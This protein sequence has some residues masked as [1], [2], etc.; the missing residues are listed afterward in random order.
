MKKILY[1][2]VLCFFQ[3]LSAQRSGSVSLQWSEKPYKLNDRFQFT[4]PNFQ[5]ENFSY[6]ETRKV[7]VFTKI[8]KISDGYSGNTIQV[9]NVVYETISAEKL[10]ELD[11]KSIPNAINVYSEVVRSRD[12]FSNVLQFSPIILE[13]GIYKRVKS[14]DYNFVSSSNRQFDS[15][16][17]R[18]VSSSVLSSGTWKKFYVDKSGVYK[19][20]KQFLS[21]LGFAVN[22]DPRTIKL[23]GSG[24]EML[25]LL[26]SASYQEDLTENAIQFVGEDDGVFN[27]SDYILFYAKGLDNWS[28]ENQTHLNLYA[29]KAYYYVTSSSG[30]G[31][32]IQ[33]LS[34]P[35][36]TPD[37]VYTSFDDYKFLEEDKVNIVRLGRKWYGDSFSAQNEKDFDFNFPNLVTTTP[38]LVNVNGAASGAVSTSFSVNVGGQDQGNLTFSAINPD[39]PV[40]ASSNN[41]TYSVNLTSG[42]FKVKLKYNNNG[43]PSATGYLDYISVRA[44]SQLRGFGKQFLFNVDEVAINVGVCEYQIAN[45]SAISQVWDVTDIYNVSAKSNNGQSQFSV[46]ATMGEA[47]KYIA[48]DNSDFY[49]PLRDSDSSVANQDL[50]GDVFK[51]SQGNFQDVDYLIVT[52]QFLLSQAERLANFH[53]TTNQLKVKVV[54]LE[55][56]Y[57]EFSSGKQDI[58]AIRNFVKYIYKNASD[59]TKKI[60]YVC[61]FGDA[62]YDFKNRIANNTN[63]VPVFYSL[64]S[65]SLVSSFISD[66]YFGMMDNNEGN[67]LSAQGLD[68]AVGR[69]LVSTLAQAE[70]MVSKVIDYHDEKSYGKWRNNLVFFSDDVDKESD[71]T[72]QSVVDNLANTVTSNKPFFNAKKIH[73][74]SYVQETTSGGQKYPKAKEDFINSFAQG[75][76]IFDYLGHGSEDVLAQERYFENVDAQNLSNKYK[77]PLFIT[78]T[79]EFTRFDN[80]FHKTGGEFT[81][82]NPSGGAVSMVTTTRQIGQSTGENFNQRL[83]QYLFA[84]GS[85][86]Y[87]S[88]AEAVRLTKGSMLNSGNNVVFYIGDPALKLAIPRPRITLTKINDVPVNAVTE[89]LKALS[90]VKLSGEVTDEFNT[91]LSNYNG[92]LS[93]NIF[94]KEIDR[95]TLGNDGTMVGGV[96]HKMNFKTL[97]ETI[98]RGNAS[99]TNGLFEFS[100]V[101]P[102]DIKIAEGNGKVSF[103]AKKNNAMEDQTG[104]D[105]TIRIGGLNTSAEVDNTA[106]RVRLYM[107]DESFVSG[108]ITNESPMFLAFL[109]DE[110]GINTA[111]GIGH[112]IIAYLDGDETKQYV[113]NDYYETELDDY[114]KGK[115]KFPF[116]NL[117]PGLHTLTFKAWDVYNNLITSELQFIVVDDEKLVLKNVLNYPNPFVNHTEFWFTHNKPFEPLEVQV[118]VLTISGK[119][120]WSKNQTITTE[121]FTSRDITWDGRDDYGDRIGKGVYVYKLTVKSTL[122][123]K[124]VE[125]FEKLVIL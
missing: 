108:G 74:D 5:N 22:V 21:E 78:V 120:V 123:N 110:N 20:S 60:K 58:G 62:S 86:N 28:D 92:E 101:V 103:Y 88:I 46:L 50:K 89:P 2:L 63:I 66:D 100:F 106:P 42:G 115:L 52:P 6:D 70:Q 37:N 24:G 69:M 4:I 12:D 91:L 13:N 45:A 29:T 81:Y 105:T 40:Y 113:L 118:Q 73:A 122:T 48:I 32:R 111:S 17:R 10:G 18:A 71:A 7:I 30:N 55:K 80:P 27:D 44:K 16:T 31:K 109:E 125:K 68:I 57:T 85:N 104:F 47:R 61:L 99:V 15:E 35:V 112:D 51:D 43:V 98:F 54:T 87:V 67:M 107:N 79:C 49:S 19:I 1:I 3:L 96:V 121:G 116:Q 94:D 82:W 83:A 117:T 75:A 76:L 77:Y 8:L 36:T 114:T 33:S 9:S 97:G 72:L 38:V 56:L 39:G 65:F 11:K 102:K 124:K 26:N 59:P 14:L 53:R 23:Y 25:P 84:Y 93:I 119:V 34:E 90:L 41:G 95:T 64:D